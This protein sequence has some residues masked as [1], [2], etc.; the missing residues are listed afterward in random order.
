MEAETKFDKARTMSEEHENTNTTQ[1]REKKNHIKCIL[2]KTNQCKTVDSNRYRISQQSSVSPQRMEKFN[3]VDVTTLQ[4]QENACNKEK[5]DYRY[6][7]R[8]EWRPRDTSNHRS[9]NHLQLQVDSKQ[10]WER[11]QKRGGNSNHA[12]SASR[13]HTSLQ[14]QRRNCVHYI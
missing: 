6:C 2:P 8:R 4:Q 1:G 13:K 10:Q 7:S 14:N 9:S 11:Y 12:N 5:V 3:I